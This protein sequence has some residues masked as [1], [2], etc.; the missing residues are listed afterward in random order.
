MPLG[1]SHAVSATPSGSPISE[2]KIQREPLWKGNLN[3]AF[4][5]TSG[6]T[7]VDRIFFH[8]QACSG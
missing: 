6:S 3:L 5:S 2:A 7:L 8:R 4:S 1:K